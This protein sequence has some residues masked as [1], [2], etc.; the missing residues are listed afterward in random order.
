MEAREGGGVMAGMRR[1]SFP[2][3]LSFSLNPLHICCTHVNPC[4]TERRGPFPSLHSPTRP[5][6]PHHHPPLGLTVGTIKTQK[7][8]GGGGA[9]KGRWVGRDPAVVLCNKSQT[10]WE[11]PGTPASITE[12]SAPRL[13]SLPERASPAHRPYPHAPFRR[14]LHGLKPPPAKTPSSPQVLTSS[15]TIPLHRP[16]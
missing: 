10:L 1:N 9:M 4:G 16:C 3:S 7:R 15:H 5:P 8:R 13:Q 6:P 12:P 14:A 2:A 11:Q